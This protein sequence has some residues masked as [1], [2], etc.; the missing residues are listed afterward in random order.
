MNPDTIQI[1]KRL[2]KRR[3]RSSPMIRK[4]TS[5]WS[6]GHAGKNSRKRNTGKLARLSKSASPLLRLTGRLLAL[7]LKPWQKIKARSLAWIM[8]SL[9]PL[10]VSA[11]LER[12]LADAK[13]SRAAA[14][15][16]PQGNLIRPRRIKRWHVS[17]LRLLCRMMTKL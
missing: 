16:K 15:K 4:L 9:A 17:A 10:F 3:R 13:N 11:L 14:L 8:A 12:L 2:E 7:L 6:G 5:F 1:L